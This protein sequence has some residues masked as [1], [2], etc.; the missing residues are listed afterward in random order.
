[1]RRAVVAYVVERV[2][3]I[4]CSPFHEGPDIRRATWLEP[5]VKVELSYNE[6]MEGRLRDP[7]LRKIV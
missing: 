6:M 4:P 7:V 5:R 1:M 2:R 3:A